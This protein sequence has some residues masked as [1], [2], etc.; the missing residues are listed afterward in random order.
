MNDD[1]QTWVQVAA[2]FAAVRELL[3]RMR[4]RQHEIEA[5][6]MAQ[7][8]DISSAEDALDTLL[9]TL[10]SAFVADNSLIVDLKAQLAA[11]P[12]GLTAA[13]GD[14]ILGRLTAAQK[15]VS[16]ALTAAAQ[17]APSTPTVPPAAS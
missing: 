14:A 5:L 3:G 13:Q 15:T 16:D 11:G 12:P 8:D 10:I 4:Q 2:S 7:N 6:H 17:A 1:L 9:S